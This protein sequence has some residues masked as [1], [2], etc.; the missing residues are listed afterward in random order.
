M[1]EVTVKHGW[2]GSANY[3]KA[4][5]MLKGIHTNDKKQALYFPIPGRLYEGEGE[6]PAWG[7]LRSDFDSDNIDRAV[8]LFAP[9][10]QQG[11][12]FDITHE[13]RKKRTE[14]HSKKPKDQFGHQVP[15]MVCVDDLKPPTHQAK[16]NVRVLRHL[17]GKKVIRLVDIMPIFD[18]APKFLRSVQQP[19]KQR[20]SAG[21]L[22]IEGKETTPWDNDYPCRGTLFLSEDKT[23][24]GKLT[25]FD[26]HEGFQKEGQKTE[27]T[28]TWSEDG[29]VTYDTKIFSDT[30]KS[31]FF[32]TYELQYESGQL[33]GSYKRNDHDQKGKVLLKVVQLASDST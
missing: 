3:D 21:T 25:Y 8:M 30:H 6:T 31:Q 33:V 14:R 18:S 10:E 28:G 22:M 27:F 7:F 29:A 23:I 12:F 17:S 4:K 32:Y 20:L 13:K 16:I 11:I 2:E 5:R 1:S 15:S 9:A 26:H 24:F 19:N